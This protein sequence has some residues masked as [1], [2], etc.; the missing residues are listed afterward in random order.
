MGFFRQEYWS[1]LQFL[2]PGD[3]PIPGI[4][5]IESPALAGGFFT[6][7]PPGKPTLDLQKK[8]R[9]QGMKADWEKMVREGWRGKGKKTEEI[10][11]GQQLS[12]KAFWSLHMVAFEESAPQTQICVLFSH[13]ETCME[14]ISVN[15]C[16]RDLPVILL[17]ACLGHQATGSQSWWEKQN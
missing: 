7:E 1:G 2:S 9:D 11:C 3:L 17:R 15:L 14:V 5:P 6:A 10:R 12:S 8:S 4:K 13:L 16:L